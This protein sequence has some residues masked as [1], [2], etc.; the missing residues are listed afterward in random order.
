MVDLKNKKYWF[1]KKLLKKIT[2][3]FLKN[4]ATKNRDNDYVVYQDVFLTTFSISDNLRN[5]YSE[6]C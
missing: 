5:V 3:I 6:K 1:R 4:G 2:E